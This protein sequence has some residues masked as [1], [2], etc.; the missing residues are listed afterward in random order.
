LVRAAWFGGD[1]RLLSREQTI[2]KARMLIFGRRD[3]TLRAFLLS[4]DLGAARLPAYHVRLHCPLPV[5]ALTRLCQVGQ[6][7]VQELLESGHGK[8]APADVGPTPEREMGRAAAE[9]SAQAVGARQGYEPG[10]L[11]RYASRVQYTLVVRG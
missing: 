2:L 9:L 4:A 1:C 10:H 3:A 6:R 8:L 11:R 5:D 7:I